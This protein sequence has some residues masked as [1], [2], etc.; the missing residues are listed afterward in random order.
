M[1]SYETMY[2]CHFL[3]N[4]ANSNYVNYLENIKWKCEGCCIHKNKY[5]LRL[6]S[7]LTLKS[8]AGN[9][10]FYIEETTADKRNK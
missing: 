6:Q 4:S 10:I 7:I 1:F 8:N 3:E 2:F 5:N 9:M